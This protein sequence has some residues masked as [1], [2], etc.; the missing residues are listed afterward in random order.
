M[1]IYQKH[2]QHLK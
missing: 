2:L 1:A